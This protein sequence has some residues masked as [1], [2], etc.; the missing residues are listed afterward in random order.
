[1][2]GGDP[3]EQV[4]DRNTSVGA[5]RLENDKMIPHPRSPVAIPHNSGKIKTSGRRQERNHA[6]QTVCGI[7]PNETL[8]VA[9]VPGHGFILDD[10][11]PVSLP[12]AVIAAISSFPF[13]FHRMT[14]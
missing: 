8:T 9:L 5:N 12:R 3:Q 6:L 4:F 11:T 7:S 13:S 14:S 1:M 2:G 10:A